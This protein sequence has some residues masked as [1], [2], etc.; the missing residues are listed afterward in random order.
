MALL[1]AAAWTLVAGTPRDPGVVE[2][3][4][5]AD[6]IDVYTKDSWGPQIRAI[7][8]VIYDSGHRTVLTFQF[9][10]ETSFDFTP[11]DD[12]TYQGKLNED[13]VSVTRGASETSSSPSTFH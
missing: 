13:C 11:P 4:G 1:L 8:Q 9:E 10:K 5:L 12:L 2:T 7:Y 3:G 6:Y